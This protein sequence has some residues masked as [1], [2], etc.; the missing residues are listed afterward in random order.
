MSVSIYQ[1]CVANTAS[2]IRKNPA[3][4]GEAAD[5]D[6]FTASHVLG[7]AFMKPKEEV[8]IDIVNS[9]ADD[10]LVDMGDLAAKYLPKGTPKR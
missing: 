2:Y 8:A 9:V 10:C 1:F 3:K 4:D 6:I 5:L 7:I